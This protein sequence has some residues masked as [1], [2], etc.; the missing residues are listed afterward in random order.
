MLGGND[1]LIARLG[2]TLHN[3]CGLWQPLSPQVSQRIAGLEPLNL[4]SHGILPIPHELGL[5]P[6]KAF[7]D[8]LSHTMGNKREYNARHSPLRE[9]TDAN[10]IAL[11]AF[12]HQAALSAG[13]RL[14]KLKGARTKG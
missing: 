9:G 2:C 3:A 1:N 13:T 11:F 14:G 4:S 8:C 5:G 10:P 7:A 12:G 6:I